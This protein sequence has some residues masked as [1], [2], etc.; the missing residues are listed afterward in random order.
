MKNDA[1]CYFIGFAD[2]PKD[3]DSPKCRSIQN[4]EALAEHYQIDELNCYGVCNLYVIRTAQRRNV[5]KVF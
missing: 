5:T 1:T 4:A 3:I 2:E